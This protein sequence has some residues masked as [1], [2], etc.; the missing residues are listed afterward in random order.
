MEAVL[1]TVSLH[2]LLRTPRTSIRGRARLETALDEPMRKGRLRLA[3][4]DAG[5]LQSEWEET[6]GAE[7]VRVALTRWIEL[8][9]II[10]GGSLPK[11][12]HAVGRKL[13][14]LGFK[15]TIDKIVLRLGLV[16]TD[17]IVVSD[18]SDF[19]EPG[20]PGL[21]GNR[22]ARVARLCREELGVVVTLLRPLLSEIS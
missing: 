7:A 14:Q 1:D 11:I 6:C 5:G 15:D 4:D 18:D 9:A 16:V 22:N 17:R 12:P 19:W 3:L 8:K 20:S 10:P 21:R 13:R 2:H